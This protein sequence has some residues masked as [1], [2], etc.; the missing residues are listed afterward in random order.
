QGDLTARPEA[1]EM[2]RAPTTPAPT[3]STGQAPELEGLCA[4]PRRPEGAPP[5]LDELLGTLAHEL[6][7][8]LATIVSAAQVIAHDGVIDPTS[9][10]ALAVLDRQARQAMRII[11]DL[12][13]ISAGRWGKLELRKEVV[14][15]AEVVARA[16]ETAAHLLTERQHRVTVS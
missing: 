9:R 2:C 16:A 1:G 15:L 13:D 7:S 8:P 3:Q 10:R 11:N 5:C 12:F 6:R 14:V 4:P